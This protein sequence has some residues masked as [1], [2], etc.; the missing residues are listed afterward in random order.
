MSADRD[1]FI[2]RFG[3]LWE[4]DGAPRI[5]GRIAGLALITEGSLSLDEIATRLGV[6]KAS[7]SNDTRLLERMG[8]IERVSRPGDRKDYYQSTEGSFER[9]IGERLRRMYQYEALIAS[10]QA[11]A[12]DSP[13][14]RG[15]LADHHFAFSHVTKALEA[16]LEALKAKRELATV[17]AAPHRKAK[18]K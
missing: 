2:E 18:R 9:L 3:L 13:A 8:F 17:K 11:L 15:R 1:R 4:E 10:G 12:V 14:V 6:S 7:V 5:A 16:A